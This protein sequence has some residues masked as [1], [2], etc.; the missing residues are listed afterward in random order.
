MN[1]FFAIKKGNLSQ[2]E[3]IVTENHDSLNERNEDDFTPLHL[4][5]LEGQLEIA[6]YLINQG[7]DVNARTNLNIT[8]LHLSALE[9]R[10]EIVKLLLDKKVKADI[11]AEV[12][13]IGGGN[14]MPIHMSANTGEADVVKILLS[15]KPDLID[16]PDKN[17]WTPLKIACMGGHLD[18]AKVLIQCGA[19][20]NARASNM[21]TPFY[22]AAVNG[23]LEMAELLINNGVNIKGDPL[24]RYLVEI[25]S[26]IAPQKPYTQLSPGKNPSRLNRMGKYQEIINLLSN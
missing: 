11:Q 18:V 16:A 12:P 24:N 14:W 2:I 17:G 6:G 1:I 26:K 15:Y 8:S 5:C 3:S 25:I 20:V 22:E 19:N 21:S 23:D 13:E 9:G 7:A 4:A 10:V